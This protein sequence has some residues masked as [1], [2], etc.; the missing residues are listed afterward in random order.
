MSAAAPGS[1]EPRW[2]PASNPCTTSAS[3]PAL[4]AAAASAALV[5]VTQA[6]QPASWS[7]LS[8]PSGQPNANETTGTRSSR[9]RASFD[10]QWSSS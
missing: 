2:P 5:T 10:F 7:E 3:A 8:T 9:A 4:A 6:S 1:K